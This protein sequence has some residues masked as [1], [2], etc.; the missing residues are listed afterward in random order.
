MS[1]IEIVS[2]FRGAERLLIVGGGIVALYLGSLLS[3]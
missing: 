1:V 3:G 2:L